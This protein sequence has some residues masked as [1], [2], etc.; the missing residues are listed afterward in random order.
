MR[1]PETIAGVRRCSGCRADVGS[2]NTGTY[3]SDELDAPR[4]DHPLSWLKHSFKELQAVAAVRRS[5]PAVL[6]SLLGM[7][8]VQ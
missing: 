5:R 4:F 6:G 8:L 7:S 1:L 3:R 2:V